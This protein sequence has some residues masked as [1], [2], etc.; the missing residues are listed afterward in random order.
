MD[1][2][3]YDLIVSLGCWCAPAAN[4]RRRFGLTEAMPFDWWVIP[5]GGLMRML[6]ERFSGLLQAKNLELFP[7]P[8]QPRHSVRCKYYDVL[9]HHDFERDEDQAVKPTFLTQLPEVQKKTRFIVERFF[10]RVRDR[11]VLFLRDCLKENHW[12]PHYG[13][14]SH[15]DDSTQFAYARNLYTLLDEQFRPREFDLFVLS[16]IDAQPS[17]LAE[18]GAIEFCFLWPRL[19]DTYFWDANYDKLF[20]EQGVLLAQDSMRAIR[21]GACDGQRASRRRWLRWRD[22]K[23]ARI[24]WKLDQ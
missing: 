15:P 24:A 13:E 6:S 18:K 23:I 9:H 7:F 3:P 8:N 20:D 5:Y 16:N 1:R 11:R 22:S 21:P 12:F 17:F 2:P 19:D 10:E 14:I 4:I